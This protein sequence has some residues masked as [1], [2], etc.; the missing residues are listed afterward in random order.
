MSCA[1]TLLAAALA[2]AAPGPEQ[3]P[4]RAAV[5]VGANAAAPGRAALRHAHRDARAIADVLAT[6]GRFGSDR[7][8]VL[9][10]PAP[11]EL[12]AAVERA[13][14]ALSGRGGAMLFF[15]FSGHAGDGA[16][17]TG[18]RGV[19][20]EAL[21]RTLDRADVDV[22]IG[23]VDACEGGGW[24]RA[25]GLVP[26]A[27]FAVPLAALLGSEGSALI[28]SSSGRES[29][30]ES[31]ALGGSFF[32]HHLAAGLRGAAD[33][34]GDGLVTLTEAFEY[35][36]VATI[37]DSAREA[38]EPQ[39]PSFAINLRG[40]SDVVLAQIG[41]SPSTLALDQQEGPL[42]V[43]HLATGVRVVELRPGRRELTLALPAGRY[44]VRKVAPG[45][46]WAREVEVAA[47]AQ[48]F[49][50]EADLV[51]VAVGRLA[52]KGPPR[53]EVLGASLSRS[54]IEVGVV[55]GSADDAMWA[56]AFRG[57]AA[58]GVTGGG[59]LDARWQITDRLTWRVGT[60]GFAWRLGRPDGARLLPYGGLLGWRVGTLR[61]TRGLG[62]MARV[63]AGAAVVAPAGPVAVLA[64]VGA[65]LPVV[66]DELHPGDPPGLR[67][68]ASLGLGVR[69]GPSVSM[70]FGVRA[71]VERDALVRIGS[72]QEIGLTTLP[73]LR[74]QAST[75]WSL[76]LDASIDGH[77]LNDPNDRWGEWNASVRVGAS[78]LF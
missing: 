49:A 45:G 59:Q 2:L 71:S 66:H 61:R 34:G 19:S 62:A 23:V 50:G 30:H 38:R 31:D 73:L 24:T 33:E 54:T 67:P 13:A 25:K 69:F 14:G 39:H 68:D 32:T 16:L 27:P 56:A 7:V 64:S 22:R 21:R 44:L 52:A 15:Y 46:V 26:E 28:A 41:G 60:L 53:R 35:A 74:I 48:A 9:L 47:R 40:R 58:I 17:Y 20:I 18:G 65:E 63:G 1:A 75:S 5:V 57:G 4:P 10:D 8:Q 70:N 37:R 3:E 51:R 36:R 77:G 6:V 76:D 72:V 29:A 43:V 55:A 78:A 42:E 11:T 12:L